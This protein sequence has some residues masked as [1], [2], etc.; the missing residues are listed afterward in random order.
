[1]G[2]GPAEQNPCRHGG[3]EC[4]CSCWC[5]R[6]GR[7]GRGPVEVREGDVRDMMIITRQDRVIINNMEKEV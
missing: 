5:C 3:A 7:G 6:P 4:L 2:E 1:M